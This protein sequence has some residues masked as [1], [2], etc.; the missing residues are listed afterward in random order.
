MP[1][2]QRKRKTTYDSNK[3]LKR[4]FYKGAAIATLV[5]V[6]LSLIKF[7]GQ[8]PY[9]PYELTTTWAVFLLCYTSFKEM[10]R[11]NDI[12]DGETY[13]GGLWTLL[14]LGGAI[15]MITWD[16]IRTLGFHLPSIPFPDDYQAATIEAIVLYTLSIIS[17]LV[18]KQNKAKRHALRQQ[19]T[20]VK[21]VRQKQAPSIAAKND[22]AADMR[23][24]QNSEI[25]AVLTKATSL[26]GEDHPPN[27][28]TS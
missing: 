7:H 13:H 22:V 21:T 25:Q 27:E 10:L 18:Y 14:V 5:Y 3:N 1:F 4:R 24:A 8:F 28:K 20:R 12:D 16:V 26:D 15:W 11:W 2:L 17:S 23:P 19:K 6:T 9:F